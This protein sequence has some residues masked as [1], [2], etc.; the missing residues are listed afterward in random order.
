V[1]KSYDQMVEAKLAES[2][3]FLEAVSVFVARL[4]AS[5]TPEIY[6]ARLLDG[7]AHVRAPLPA[8]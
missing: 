8:N 4:R 1:L 3:D 5:G 2:A 6:I 7:L